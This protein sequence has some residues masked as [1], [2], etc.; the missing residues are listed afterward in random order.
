MMEVSMSS[1]V[2]QESEIKFLETAE[3]SSKD[4]GKLSSRIHPD[5]HGF[6]STKA[7]LDSKA[8]RNRLAS[9]SLSRT[10]LQKEGKRGSISWIISI[11]EL[12]RN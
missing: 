5:H 9:S 4:I 6:L 2:K 11:Y 12:I 3:S 1:T 8:A 7:S 10:I